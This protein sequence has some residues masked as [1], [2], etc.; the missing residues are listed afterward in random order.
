M[1]IKRI[2]LK[3]YRCY[4]TLT[5]T[6]HK[7]LNIIIGDNAQGKT[8]ILEAIHVLGL[9]KSH[10]FSKDE[11][12]I[13]EG[14]THTNIQAELAFR[15]KKT[16]LS[17]TI[18]KTGKK[19]KYNRIEMARLS[20]YIGS[21]NLVMFSPE[22]MEL[23]KGSPRERR[24]FLDIDLGQLSKP[25]MLNLQHYRRLLKERNE[26]LKGLSKK[27]KY[28]DITLD[29]VT[30]QLI[31]YAEKII[32][33][34]SEFIKQ[35]QVKVNKILPKLSGETTSIDVQYTPSIKTNLKA[36]FDKKK[37]FDIALQTTQLGP[38]RDEVHFLYKGQL[39][40]SYASQ[41]Q[42]RSLVIALKLA[43]VEMIIETKQRLPIILLDDVFSELDKH[44]QKRVLDVFSQ[45]AQVFI[46]TTHIDHIHLDASKTYQTIEIQA[47]KIKGVKHHG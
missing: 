47:G 2:Q 32:Q 6:P 29:V 26:V 25:Y 14:A 36:V 34:R 4:D 15:D 18:S 42:I 45:E 9:T 24:R 27:E 11:D 43:V 31:H 5:L 39:M 28:D 19:A 16:T 12:L 8:S 40:K 13:K 37:K 23:V 10:K 1:N 3:N 33:T 17:M 46:T 35:L 38:H 7:N 41:G 30:E 44:R 20:D 22:D 21:F